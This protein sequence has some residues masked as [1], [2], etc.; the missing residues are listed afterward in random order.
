VQD[1]KRVR[2]A[3]FK[4]IERIRENIDLLNKY[5]EFPFADHD[6]G[7]NLY[8]T[9]EPLYEKIENIGNFEE[10]IN[11]TK[12]IVTRFSAGNVGVLFSAFLPDFIYIFKEKQDKE[13]IKR[14]FKEI[15]E[16]LGKSFENPQPGTALS[17]FEYITENPDLLKSE[18]FCKKIEPELKKWTL[19]IPEQK[20]KGYPD[21]GLFAVSLFIDEFLKA[22]KSENIDIKKN[23]NY[24]KEKR[25]FIKDFFFDEDVSI[26]V[27]SSADISEELA[28][29]HRIGIIPLQFFIGI[30]RF[31]DGLEI[32]REEI[33]KKIKEMKENLSTSQPS[34]DDIE[35][36]IKRACEKARKTLILTIAGKLSGTFGTI[37]AV[38]ENISKDKVHVFDSK[39][40]SLALTIFALRAREKI[41][42]GVSFDKMLEYL[43]E[44][45]DKSVLLFSLKT[46]K[47][48]VKSGR[49]SWGQGKIATLLNIK[50]VMI[51]DD[52]EI[53]KVKVAFGDKGTM[54][55]IIELLEEKL[56]K[57][58]EYDFAVAHV[59]REE[60]IEFFKKNLREKF[61]MKKFYVS[62]L[63]PVIS[64]HVGPGAFGVFAVPYL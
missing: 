58:F 53:K 15:I 62:S 47:Y 35:E 30:K 7:T 13:K 6:T 19:L 40:L 60:V 31:R 28:R 16:N 2:Y 33:Y 38:A 55:K 51:L 1:F 50:P 41:K 56:D 64:I 25:K 42:E 18:N 59:E 54:K 10:L 23:T 46:L 22:M 36:I 39:F 63:T 32:K 8:I 49:I 20:K 24:K 17:L 45:R 3:L 57:N 43:R 44:I 29:K 52:G 61:K 9:L 26:I 14:T 11:E 37:K 21:S 34:I 4:S 27:D 48:L 5:N 12:R